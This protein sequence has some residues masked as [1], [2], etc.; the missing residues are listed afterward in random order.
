MTT[1]NEQ[2]VLEQVIVHR[3]GN[4]TRGEAIT[5]SARP[6]TLNDEMLRQLLLKYFLSA[7][8]R[9]ELF[10]FHHMNHLDQNEVYS[11]ARQVLHDEKAFLQAS[12]L[13]ARFLHQKSTHVRVKAG[14]LYVASMKQVWFEND[15]HDAI[16]IFKCETKDNFLRVID[17]GNS[18]EVTCE[19]GITP[20]KPDKGCLI[21]KTQEADGYRVCVIDHTNKQHD[22]QYWVN[23][24][25]QVK[26][27]LN[28]YHNTHAY[29]S[30]CKQFA[31]EQMP[32]QF[33][34]TKG[35]QIDLMQRSLEY[36]KEKEQFNLQEFA[37]EVIHHP[38][39]V[40]QFMD[41]RQRFAQSAGQPL[42][43]SFDISLSAVKK[44]Q[45]IFKSIL[46]LDKNFHIYI[47]GRRDLIERGYDEGVGK[48][49]Y[50]VYFDEEQ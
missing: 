25:L 7:F 4:P 46:K 35:Q 47:H 6:L 45:K 3:V 2:A 32:E 20:Q 43:E 36:F 44:Q 26:P 17:H 49:Y 11:F 42:E 16:G 34:V 19:E 14:E 12:H 18:F 24:F 15:Y 22:A 31:T 5:L 13:I 30:I 38:D 9:E 37:E 41:F 21:I 1:S 48:H 50:K 39:M 27:V 10:Q 33:E 29:L 28:E 8:N 23:D 40:D